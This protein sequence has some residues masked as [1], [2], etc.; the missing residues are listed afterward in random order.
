MFRKKLF[1]LIAVI[2]VFGLLCAGCGAK[3]TDDTSAPATQNGDE[4]LG[5]K[6]FKLSATT[7]SSPNGAT[8]NLT[9]TPAGYAD[10]QTATFVVRLEGEDVASMPCTYEKGVYTASVDLNGE[11]GYC[12]YV[13]MTATDGNTAEVPVNVPTDPIDE[14]LINMA[15]SLESSCSLLVANSA[16][17]GKWLSI[18]SGT[19]QI[20]PPRIVN[21][22]ETITCAKAE[23]ILSLNDVETDRMELEMPAPAADGSYTLSLTDTAFQTPAMEDDQQLSVRLDVTLSNGQFLSASGG[24][25]FYNDGSLLMAVG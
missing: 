11:D 19:I 3:K 6:D 4:I 9:A 21:E 24:T 18:T 8:V 13:L 25:W 2:L 15:S 17:D 22:G 12:Y 20:N 1:S 23:L 16:Y 7:W 14:S 10:G 5:L